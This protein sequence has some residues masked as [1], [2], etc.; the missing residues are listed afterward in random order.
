MKEMPLYT[1]VSLDPTPHKD[2]GGQKR[3]NTEDKLCMEVVRQALRW[4]KEKQER[5]LASLG[6]KRFYY[7]DVAVVTK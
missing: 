4:P 1:T 3:P 2:A 6:D 7:C 5:V